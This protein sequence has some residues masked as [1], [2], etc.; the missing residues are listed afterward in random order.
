MPTAN[1]YIQLPNG[2]F[3]LK[4]SVTPESAANSGMSTPTK[5][6]TPSTTGASPS[7][8]PTGRTVISIPD[9][10]WRGLFAEY[11]EVVGGTTEAPDIY[12]FGIFAAVLGA[13]L[14]RRLWVYYGRETYPN[15]Y[16]CEVGTSALTRKGT[17]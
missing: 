3:V 2:R 7:I 12:H 15:F 4:E 6:V 10:V 5:H 1:G 17:A 14:G 8:P 9:S 11:R 16:I 13:T